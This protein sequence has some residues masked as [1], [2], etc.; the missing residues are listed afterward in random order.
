MDPFSLRFRTGP[1][2]PALLPRE[3]E[4]LGQQLFARG[5]AVL[6]RG[7]PRPVM[8]VLREAQVDQVDIAQVLAAPL[9]HRERMLSAIAGQQA[10]TAAALVGTL[11]LERKNR[12]RVVARSRALAVYL[13][14][15]DNRWWTCWQLVGDDRALVGDGPLVRRAVDGEPR[16]GGIGGWFARARR[17]G[18]RL[19]V[20]RPAG[21]EGLDNVH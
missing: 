7:L 2:D 1:R 4:A 3:D 11:S 12:G 8:L 18:L 21:L 10:V 15:P 16:P 6:D 5:C 14:W 13:E 17:E 19:Q 20:R 9:P